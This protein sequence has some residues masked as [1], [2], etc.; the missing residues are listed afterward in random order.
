MDRK[1]SAPAEPVAWCVFDED[2]Q[3]AYVAGWREA[4]HEHINDALQEHDIAE[5]AKWVVRPLYAVPQPQPQR[6][7]LTNGEIYTAY[8]EA[9]NQ[10]LRPQDE[11]LAL[12]FARAI[13]KALK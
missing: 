5:A 3:P 1:Q 11:R 13:E 2:N 6:E 7:L 8:I 9:T 10:T 4:C 12:A